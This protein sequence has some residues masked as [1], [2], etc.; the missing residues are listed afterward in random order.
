M[1]ESMAWKVTCGKVINGRTTST[2]MDEV[3]RQIRLK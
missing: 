2:G 3:T 1:M